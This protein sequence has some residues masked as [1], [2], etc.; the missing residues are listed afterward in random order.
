MNTQVIVMTQWPGHAAG[1]IE[2]PVNIPIELSQIAV[3]PL[4]SLTESS[5]RLGSVC[6]ND[7]LNLA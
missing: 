5:L 7:L 6:R 3:F 1:E 4:V 2:R